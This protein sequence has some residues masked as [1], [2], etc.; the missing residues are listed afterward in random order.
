M[1][2]NADL[3]ELLEELPRAEELAERLCA[4]GPKA[5]HVSCSET[6]EIKDFILAAASVLRGLSVA[7]GQGWLPI[8]SAP[9]DGSMVLCWVQ[10]VR[11]GEDDDGRH[12]ETD[13]S[14]CDFGAWHND[15]H[16]GYFLA[17]AS[18]RADIENPTYWQPLPAAPAQ[19]DG[20]E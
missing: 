20:V 19:P 16:G 17:F 12:Y 18:P 7:Q 13:V 9:R 6:H 4:S 14:E 11:F 1:T 10:A 2:A 15:E 5:A 3:R 8:E